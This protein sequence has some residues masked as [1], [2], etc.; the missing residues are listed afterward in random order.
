[1]RT[2]GLT[3]NSNSVFVLLKPSVDWM[4]PVHI[5]EGNLLYSESADLNTIRV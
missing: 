2:Q 4:R 3:K 1:M 5:M